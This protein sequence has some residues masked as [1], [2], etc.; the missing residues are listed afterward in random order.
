VAAIS[1]VTGG[2]RSGKSAYA[3]RLAESLAPRRLFVATAP[4]TD[5][6]MRERIERHRAERAQRGWDTIEEPLN[7]ARAFATP[8]PHGVV[9]LDCVTLW[10]NNL[11]YEAE[12]HGHTLDEPQIVE[13]CR[14][15]LDAALARDGSIVIVTNEVGMDIVPENRL[16]RLYRDLLG[17]A[18]QTIAAR[19]DTVTLVVCGIPWHLKG[20]VCI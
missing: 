15:M 3:Q 8:T 16:A 5:P 9:L 1:L 14:Q 2:C 19:A 13:H 10:I 7:L 18:N 12:Q 20:S 11:L 6:E 4:V 17:R